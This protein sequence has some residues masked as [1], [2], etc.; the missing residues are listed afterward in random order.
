MNCD[1]FFRF[2]ET[3]AGSVEAEILKVQNINNIKTLL[4]STDL[5]SF[6]QLECDE[7]A[8]LRK[9]ACFQLND[10]TFVVKPVI[11]NNL[12]HCVDV[13]SSYHHSKEKEK[14]RCPEEID[15]EESSRAYDGSLAHEF[16][17]NMLENMNRSKN[18]YV[19]SSSIRRFASALYVLGGR[20]T[21][22]FL[23]IN[24]PGALPACS[25]LEIYNDEL[26]KSIEEGEFRF[27]ELK[28]H[29]DQGGSNYIFCSE[30]CTGAVSRIQYN[31]HTNSFIGFCPKLTNGVPE[32]RQFSFDRFEQ[33]EHA[34]QT[35]QKSTLVNVHM[36]QPISAVPLST[37]LLS[38]FGTENSFDSLS[39]I[40]RWIFIDEQ[41]LA[42]GIRIDGFA[43]DADGKYLKAMKYV[44]GES[45]D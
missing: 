11:K 33:L 23:R 15:P 30:D 43:S 5:F 10:G 21:Y 27:T 44:S 25:T 38:T 39:I 41:C 6:F 7:L 13:L 42:H 31:V 28:Q 4:R 36:A 1:E 24:L 18:N 34:F 35:I 32:K 37:F 19:Y 26:C 20:N 22:E 16:T 40:R 29:L 9:N 14:K 3:N 45:N 17:K 8:A 2:I 12:Q